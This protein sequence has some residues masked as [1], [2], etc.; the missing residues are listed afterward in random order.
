MSRYEK[1][2]EQRLEKS[3][4]LETRATAIDVQTYVKARIPFEPLLVCHIQTDPNLEVTTIDK[5][6]E[7][8]KG[9]YVSRYAYP[10]YHLNILL[11]SIAFAWISAFATPSSVPLLFPHECS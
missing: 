10:A 6:V 8:S 5:K 1:S 2:I 11:T 3:K 4:P 9:M 7:K